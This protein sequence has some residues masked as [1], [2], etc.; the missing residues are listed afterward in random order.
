[1]AVTQKGTWMR[2]IVFLSACLSVSGV[3]AARAEALQI[4]A[5]ASLRE[6]VTDMTNIYE[7][8]TGQE[9][10]LVF[11]AT[12]AIARQVQQGAPADVVLLADEAWAVW[13]VDNAVVDR[14]APFASNRLVL[15]SQGARVQALPD[16]V[17]GPMI[18]MAQVDAVPAGRYGKAAFEGLGLWDDLASQVVQAA[19]V[20]AALRFVE[21]GEVP[22]AVGYASDLEAF[23]DLS[24][25]HEFPLETYP[26]ITYFGAAMT[27]EGRDFLTYIQSDTAKLVLADWGFSPLGASP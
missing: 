1:M 25:A 9:A 4:Y 3:S 15:V 24:L 20:R 26:Q 19:N 13:L 23:P 6:A 16:L 7:A 17:G 22:Y 12:S 21:R 2:S 11:A 5:A 10:V 8:E 27:G 18:A 14:L